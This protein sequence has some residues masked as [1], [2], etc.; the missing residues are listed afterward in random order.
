MNNFKKVI[1]FL[2]NSFQMPDISTDP[3]ILQRPML[4]FNC[5]KKCLEA[6][7]IKR[8]NTAFPE[9]NMLRFRCGPKDNQPCSSLFHRPRPWI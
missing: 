1:R 8:L 2:L 7:N 6:N 5:Q 3:H 4:I 9:E